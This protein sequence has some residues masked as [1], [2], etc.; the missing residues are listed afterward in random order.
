MTNGKKASVTLQWK[1]PLSTALRYGNCYKIV[2]FNQQ[3]LS[4][5]FIFQLKRV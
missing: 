1:S 4:I 2:F 5:S 3:C